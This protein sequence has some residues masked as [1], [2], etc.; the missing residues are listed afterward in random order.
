MS[1]LNGVVV[2]AATSRPDL[3]DPALL[4][5]GRLDRLLL[6]DFPGR[7]ARLE[8]LERSVRDCAGFEDQRAFNEDQLGLHAV[9]KATEGFSGADLRALATDAHMHAVH[10]A[11]ESETPGDDESVVEAVVTREDVAR[12]AREARRSVPA[13]ERERLDAV[14]RVARVMCDTATREAEMNVM[15]EYEPELKTLKA[16]P[17]ISKWN[18][19]CAA[20]KPIRK[21]FRTY[22]SFKTY[23]NFS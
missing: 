3:I 2:L 15:R 4:R 7:D 19:H 8:I 18:H 22:H 14:A 12:A 10:R 11:M 20:S 9:A 5:P 1:G 21:K 23:D 13:R 16:Q 17:P 6:C